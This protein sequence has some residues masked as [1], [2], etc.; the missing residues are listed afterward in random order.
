M[1]TMLVSTYHKKQQKKN[2]IIVQYHKT[3]CGNISYSCLKLD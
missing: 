2:Q 3:F 1:T